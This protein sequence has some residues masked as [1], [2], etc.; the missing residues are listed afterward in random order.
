MLE[1]EAEAAAPVIAGI[2]RAC[3]DLAQS[4]AEVIIPGDGVMN[5]FIWRH[6]IRTSG[7]ELLDA[8]AVL[9]HHARYMAQLRASTGL[10]VSRAGHYATPA[11]AMLEHSRALLAA[12]PAREDRFSGIGWIGATVE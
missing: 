3:R 6:R 7:V 11:R 10:G 4:G 9:M 12:R 1:A 8:A 2:E 5:D